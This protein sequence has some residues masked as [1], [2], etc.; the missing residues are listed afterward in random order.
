MSLLMVFD[1]CIYMVLKKIGCD[2]STYFLVISYFGSVCN[3]CQLYDCCLGNGE[4]CGRLRLVWDVA[5]AKLMSST[6]LL[7]RASRSAHTSLQI[8]LICL[9]H[10]RCLVLVRTLLFVCSI[11][12]LVSV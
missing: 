1:F 12:A 4:T 7:P 5:G 2:M 3:V 8:L 9:V 10:N 11:T 6:A